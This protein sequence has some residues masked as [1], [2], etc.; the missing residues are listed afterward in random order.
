MTERLDLRTLDRLAR[1]GTATIGD[2]AG[3][4]VR[5][6]DGAI[7]PIAPNGAAISG[8]AFTVGCAP[9]DNLA[10]H[11]ALLSVRPGDM[12][13]VDYGGSVETGP[14]GEIMALAAQHRGVRGLIIDGA[15]RDSAEI[16][17]MGFAVYC[18]GLAIPG[19][20]KADRGR[21]GEGAIVGGI[22]V[23]QGDVIVADR[24]AIVVVDPFDASDILDRGAERLAMEARMMDRIRQGETTC[25][26]LGLS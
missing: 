15:I 16:A 26:I 11:L 10:L 1:L 12:L 3:P 6:V 20:S 2:V 23:R 22:S 17:A 14:F 18:R 19:T 8:H 7:R 5:I 25:D 9:G 13:V 4:S 21:I 24:D